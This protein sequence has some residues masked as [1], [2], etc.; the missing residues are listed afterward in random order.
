M[1]IIRIQVTGL[2]TVLHVQCIA[3]EGVLQRC[4]C[5]A[6]VDGANILPYGL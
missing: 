3:I 6:E 5:H 1:K 4:L 2:F